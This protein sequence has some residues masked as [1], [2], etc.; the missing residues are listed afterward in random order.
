[1]K[2]NSTVSMETEKPRSKRRRTPSKK[3]EQLQVLGYTVSAKECS[4]K[5]KKKRKNKKEFTEA[6][7]LKRMSRKLQDKID[8]LTG[9]FSPTKSKTVGKPQSS[10]HLNQSFTSGHQHLV[11]RNR[12]CLLNAQSYDRHPSTT[13]TAGCWKR[14]AL[15]VALAYWTHFHEAQS[16]VKVMANLQFQWFH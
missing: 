10:R 1:M 9:E 5:T 13:V 15:H 14:Q 16:R 3:M 7:Q 8:E 2:V 11:T 4:K 12:R 6:D